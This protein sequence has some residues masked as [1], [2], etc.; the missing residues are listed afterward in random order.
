MTKLFKLAWILVSIL[1][2]LLY[3]S[4]CFSA[5]ISATTF[6]YNIVLAIAF[7]YLVLLLFLFAFVWIF[8]N[9]K[10]AIFLFILH[11]I[12]WQNITHSYVFKSNIWQPQKDTNTLRILTW[13]VRGFIDPQG[14][15]KTE[16]EQRKPMLQLISTYNPDILCIQEYRNFENYNRSG[17]VRKELDS[18]GYIYHYFSNDSTL[19]VN[20][21][22][23]ESGVAIYSKYAFSDSNRVRIF[24]AKQKE[25]LISTDISWQ[26]K[27]L[28][29]FTAHL[30]SYSFFNDTLH[31]A[32]SGENIYQVS[33]H[34]KKSIL[35]KLIN[36]YQI[37]EKQANIIK[38]TI[39]QSPYPQVFCGDIN[40][41][42]TTY[43]YQ[44][45][46]GNLQDAYLQKGSGIGN[47]FSEL[48][49]TLR[50][51]MCFPATTFKVL[52][53][54]TVYE[55]LSDHYPVITDIQWKQ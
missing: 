3:L 29:L 44:Y 34:H 31:S 53:C 45:L 21:I 2:S 39:Q 35:I 25:H 23:I 51:D 36:I 26:G 16:P 12:G 43:T 41:T 49:P 5:H 20:K 6:A 1:V 18:M 55:K 30:L 38:N 7:P 4:S 11:F 54:T 17:C 19:H 52:Q 33:Y 50:I 27:R 22:S 42:P 46:K 32:E 10:M 9:K 40:S 13:N 15:N 37:H 28:R 14:A 8:M 47:S 24:S 48:L